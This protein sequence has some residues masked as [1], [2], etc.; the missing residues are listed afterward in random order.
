MKRTQP[1]KRASIVDEQLQALIAEMQ[2]QRATVEEVKDS[3]A[4][5]L[6]GVRLLNLKTQDHEKVG[7]PVGLCEDL[8]AAIYG[9]IGAVPFT[10]TRLLEEL[11]ESTVDAERLR[12]A[13]ACVLSKENMTPNKVARFL[14]WET[15]DVAGPWRRYVYPR[16]HFDGQRFRVWRHDEK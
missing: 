9:I 16:K 12:E 14:I 3:L 13:L 15:F 11:K 6:E 7:M 8:Y 2:S 4:E 10:A 1:L 5:L